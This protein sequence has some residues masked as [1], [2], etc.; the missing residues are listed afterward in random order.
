MYF[1]S[2]SEGEYPTK[3]T[4]IYHKK[5]FTKEEFCAMYNAAIQNI[6][7]IDPEYG[8]SQDQIVRSLCDLYSFKVVEVT[9]DICEENLYGKYPLMSDE[10]IVKQGKL[11]T[12]M[13]VTREEDL[14]DIQ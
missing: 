6:D 1:Y 5:E 10:L 2:V 13:I 14:C 8:P 12:K 7:K 4:L 3:I 9:Y 11:K